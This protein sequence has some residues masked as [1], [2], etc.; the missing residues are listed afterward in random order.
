MKIPEILRAYRKE[1]SLSLSRFAKLYGFDKGE[2]S[3]WENEKRQI[4]MLSA[5][6]LAEALG[7]D[8][9]TMIKIWIEDA[10]EFEKR[11][12]DKRKKKAQ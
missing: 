5:L 8:Q 12:H 10:R 9:K 2:I 4:S 3:R 11:G 1:H 6:K 7:I